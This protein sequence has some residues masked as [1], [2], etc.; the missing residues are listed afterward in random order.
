MSAP[1][2]MPPGPSLPACHYLHQQPPCSRSVHPISFPPPDTPFPAVPLSPVTA[3]GYFLLS[4]SKD[5]NPMVRNGENGDWIGT[6]QGH[7]VSTTRLLLPLLEPRFLTAAR[8][9]LSSGAAAGLSP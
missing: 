3:D 6:F 5:G 1:S 8:T 9:V 2:C 7:K 4:A